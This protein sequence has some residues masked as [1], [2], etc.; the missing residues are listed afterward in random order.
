MAPPRRRPLGCLRR[1]A[2]RSRGRG[3]RRRIESDR[4]VACPEW[5]RGPVVD[6]GGIEDHTSVNWL[7]AGIRQGLNNVAQDMAQQSHPRNHR[8]LNGRLGADRSTWS[9]LRTLLRGLWRVARLIAGTGHR[10]VAKDTGPALRGPGCAERARPR[11]GNRAQSPAP[12]PFAPQD[13]SSSCGLPAR[14]AGHLDG[15]PNAA[16]TTDPE[17]GDTNTAGERIRSALPRRRSPTQRS[18][19]TG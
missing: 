7:I 18:T 1:S 6:T 12:Q 11:S 17:A 4:R 16:A 15:N 14:T 10:G 9:G 13:L 8:A 3:V 19:V 2:P 5:R